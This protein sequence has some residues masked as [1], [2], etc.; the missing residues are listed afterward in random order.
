M[1]ATPSLASSSARASAAARRSAGTSARSQV[2]GGDSLGD[3]LGAL[4]RLVH[5]VDERPHDAAGQQVAGVLGDHV[6]QRHVDLVDAGDAEQAQRGALGGVRGVFLD[7]LLDVVGDRARRRS[8][9]VDQVAVQSERIVHLTT[10]FRQEET[11][12][13]IR[14]AAPR[15]PGEPVHDV[16]HGDA[17]ADCLGDRGEE[18]LGL[19]RLRHAERIHRQ[20][21]HTQRGE[22]LETDA[23]SQEAAHH[24]GRKDEHGGVAHDDAELRARRQHARE[25]VDELLGEGAADEER[26]GADP[27]HLAR[28]R[29]A[30]SDH[31]RELERVRDS[32]GRE[33]D[34]TRA[35]GGVLRHQLPRLRS[36]AGQHQ[37]VQ[38]AHGGREDVV[39]RVADHA[40]GGHDDAV[41]HAWRRAADAVDG[42]VHDDLLGAERLEPLHGD[43]ELGQRGRA[44]HL[45]GAVAGCPADDDAAE[46][47]VERQLLERLHGVA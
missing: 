42:A 39:E 35:C 26:V 5:E 3:L 25:V 7:V 6:D 28:D 4:A 47:G 40:A 30:L 18:D 31:G 14:V 19:I 27:L 21:E 38:R 33:G 17:V 45:D 36:D 8:R 9:A 20:G 43:A 32:A 37:E 41:A 44:A 15:Q 16:E 29:D 11:E 46:R 23:A 13:G 1:R 2:A 10:H 24:G 34:G 12:V 22:H